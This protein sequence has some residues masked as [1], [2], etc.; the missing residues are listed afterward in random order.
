MTRKRDTLTPIVMQFSSGPVGNLTTNFE[1]A[2]SSESF[3]GRKRQTTLMLSSA[4]ISRSAAIP[5]HGDSPQA[6]I[7]KK[8]KRL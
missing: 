1:P 6:T 7:N 8:K 3:N 5:T 4:A 2:F